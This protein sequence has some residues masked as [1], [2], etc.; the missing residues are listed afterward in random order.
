MLVGQA[1]GM[2]LTRTALVSR[3]PADLSRAL[4]AWHKP[5][6]VHDRAKIATDL[7]ITRALGGDCL[8]D[9][10]RAAW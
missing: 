1:G 9:V 10:G 6:A 5:F 8:A 7:A 2:L 4:P 3:V